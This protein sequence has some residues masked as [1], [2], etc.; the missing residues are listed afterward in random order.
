MFKK[1]IDAQILKFM[2]SISYRK[3]VEELQNSEWFTE[4]LTDAVN[5]AMTKELQAY[6]REFYES[7]KHATDFLKEEAFLDSI[8][9]RIKKNQI[10]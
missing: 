3:V 4:R 2:P 10:C 7:A 1:Y 9:E 8:I 5:R 6:K